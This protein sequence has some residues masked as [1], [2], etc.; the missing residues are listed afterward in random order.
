MLDGMV[1]GMVRWQI[2]RPMINASTP[3]PV[4]VIEDEADLRALMVGLLEGDGYP[5]VGAADGE[6]ALRLLC[7]DGLRPCLILLDLMM[8]RMDGW[9]FRA[10]Q[11]R[12]PVLAGIPVVAV[13]GYGQN[14]AA[15]PLDAVAI[16]TKPFD[17]DALL[18]VVA[19]HC[20]RRA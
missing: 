6:E 1:A 17:L 18:S 7:N 4:L 3:A 2:F 8:P 15:R 20:D 5:A 13:T 11:R 12:D 9:A 19:Q 14:L 16:L 10:R